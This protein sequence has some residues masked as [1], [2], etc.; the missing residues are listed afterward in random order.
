MR[1]LVLRALPLL[2]LIACDSPEQTDGARR[3]AT[4]ADRDDARSVTDSAIDASP[5]PDVASADIVA[6]DSAPDA[7]DAGV[8]SGPRYAIPLSTN[9]LV[10]VIGTGQSLSVGAT[11]TPAVSTRQPYQNV[12]LRDTGAPPLYDGVGDVLS[13][14]PLIEPVRGDVAGGGQ[15]Y[16]NNVAGETPHSGMA[17]ELSYFARSRAGVEFATAHSV[18]GESGRPMTYIRRGGIGRAYAASMYE[19]TALTRLARS[20]GRRF[21]V[22]AI[23]LTHGES[24]AASATYESDLRALIDAYRMD[25]API[26]GQRA[27]VPLIVS[28]QGSF[29][30]APGRALSTQAQWR[31]SVDHAGLILCSGPKYQMEYSADHVHLT[32]A[33][34][35]ALGVK[36][37]QVFAQTV[38]EGR[39][40]RPLEPVDVRRNGAAIEVQFYV[41]SPP[42]AWE[43]SIPAPHS[44]PATQTLWSAGRGFELEQNG[45]AVGIRSVEI[46]GDTVVITPASPLTVG[47]FTVRY[48]MTQDVAGYAAGTAVGRAGQLRDSDPYV[49]FDRARV[50]AMVT[51]G[52]NTVRVVSGSLEGH[53]ARALVRAEGLGREGAVVTAAS[54]ATLVLS[55]P[56]AGASGVATLE[57]QSDQRNYAVQFEWEVR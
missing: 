41:P 8:E 29:P 15:L 14:A 44:T 37:A 18:V 28:Q 31:A 32:A 26:T 45:A 27:E 22:G 2:A 36:Y 6:T 23:V 3:D 46:R 11:S 17:N 47:G 25:I 1:P 10:G 38:F 7:Q 49:G 19:I 39:R 35:R 52:S 9:V 42:L 30:G 33:G 57:V 51:A 24:D 55:T 20:E 53:G 54:A 12:R 40:W 50:M 16:P 5:S 34:S 48:A 56:W 21:E 4:A 43:S 13:L